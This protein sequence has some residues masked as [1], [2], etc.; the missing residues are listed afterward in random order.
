MY[1]TKL[2]PV[3]RKINRGPW[4]GYFSNIANTECLVEECGH[5]LSDTILTFEEFNTIW[6]ATKS[7]DLADAMIELKEKDLIEFELKMGQFRIQAEQISAQREAKRKAKEEQENAV[8]CPV[9]KSTEVELSTRGYSLFWGFAGS[10][11]PRNVCKKCGYKWKP[12]R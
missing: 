2:C 10:G 7:A 9:C 3:C 6:I 11:S 8:K 1:M 4:K 5:P 12:G